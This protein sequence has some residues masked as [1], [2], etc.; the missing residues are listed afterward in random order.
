MNGAADLDRAAEELA[1]ILPP[2]L[3]PLARIAYNYR[4]SWTPGGADLFRSIDPA[5]WEMSA[6]NPVRLLN[7]VSARDLRDAADNAGIVARGEALVEELRADGDRP[8]MPGPA[9]AERPVAF[10]CAEFAVHRSLPIYA[11]GLGVLAGDILKEASDLAV[12]M[13]AVG[14]LYR[15]GYFLQRLDSTG[16]QHEYW[17]PVDPERLPAALVRT[18]GGAPLTVTVP[19]RG[20]DIVIQVWRVNVGRVPLYLLDADRPENS[21][22]DR[23][24]TSRLYVGDRATRLAQYALLGVGSMRALEAM[25][26]DPSVVHLNEGH[27]ALAPLEIARRRMADSP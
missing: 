16:Y 24:I 25:G 21:P 27:A 18:P 22:V 12:P 17:F 8:R 20:R 6:E 13:V 15:Q 5:R 10:L 23:W 2:E 19:V 3:A 11:G 9:T 4:W 26:M 14:L 1:A 7:D